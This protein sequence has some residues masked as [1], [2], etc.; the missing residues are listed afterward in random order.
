[1]R[2]RSG[3]PLLRRQ[4][5]SL[6]IQPHM[7]S[8]LLL[9]QRHQRLQCPGAP[10]GDEAADIEQPVIRYRA[11][12]PLRVIGVEASRSGNRGQIWELLARYKYWE[13]SMPILLWLLGVPIPIIILLILFTH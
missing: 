13:V 1:M 10:V 11:H 2:S 3:A 7:P 8:D 6:E 9:R 4:R 5:L 12:L